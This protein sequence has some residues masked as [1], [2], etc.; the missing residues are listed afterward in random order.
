MGLVEA[1][2]TYPTEM[3]RFFAAWGSSS[4]MR[5]VSFTPPP[6]TASMAARPNLSSRWRKRFT[7][8]TEPSAEP[9]KNGRSVAS[10]ARQAM[11]WGKWKVVSKVL[12]ERS[13]S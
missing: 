8:W 13:Q 11:G 12:E 4:L 2:A 7:W 1:R 3:R 10:H 5:I 6:P 9:A